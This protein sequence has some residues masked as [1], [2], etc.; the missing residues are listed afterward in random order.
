MRT[1]PSDTDTTVPSLRASVEVSSFSMRD[2]IISLISDGLSCCISS[3]SNSRVQLLCQTVQ[4][5]THTAINYGITGSNQHA[6]DQGGVH[7]SADFHFAAETSFQSIDQS[8]DI[9]VFHLVSGDE[10][11]IR[12][13][14]LFGQQFVE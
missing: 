1:I 3:P 10:F 6:A 12:E 2:L 9:G 13:R 8:A 4:S 11:H 14:L 7:G 5:A